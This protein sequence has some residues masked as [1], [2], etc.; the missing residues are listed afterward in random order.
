[1]DTITKADVVGIFK[2]LAVL[3]PHSAKNYEGADALARDAWWELVKDM[4]KAL[5]VESIKSYAAANRFAPSIAELRAE[6]LKAVSPDL[7]IGADE[8]WGLVVQAIRR[9]GYGRP[10][11]ALDSLPPPVARCAERFG[12]RDICLSEEPDVVRGQFRRAYE[13]QLAREKSD[14]LVPVQVRE[15]LAQ[16]A[17]GFGELPQGGKLVVLP[18]VAR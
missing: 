15:R 5:V 1:M 8:A 6:V 9:F 4:P 2:L 3:F 16:L 13:T 7:R 17:G 14:A 12:W 11:D 10:R 18:E